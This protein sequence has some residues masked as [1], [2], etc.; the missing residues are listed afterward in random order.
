MPEKKHSKRFTE[1][2]KLVERGKEYSPDEGVKLIKETSKAKF[3]TTV[4]LHLRMGV[5]PKQADQMV[6][7]AAVLPNGTG[8][9]V[10]VIVFAQGD[11]ARDAQA[12][13]ADEVG[14]DDLAKKIAETKMNDLN[15]TSLEA[16]M[17][18]VEGTARSMG[19]EVAG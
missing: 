7:G 5:D 13:G 3:D 12:A 16:A 6:R 18:M 8:K 17:R 14:T 4:E 11:K 9:T 2:A 15:A 10:R 19:V 1:L